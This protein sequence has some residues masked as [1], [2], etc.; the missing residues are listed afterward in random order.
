MI[1]EVCSIPRRYGSP[2]AQFKAFWDSTGQLWQKGSLLGKTGGFFF[3]TA[4]QGG[5]QET[6]AWTGELPTH[7]DNYRFGLAGARMCGHVAGVGVEVARV[8]WRRQPL[9]CPVMLHSN[10]SCLRCRFECMIPTAYRS[11]L[12]CSDH[13]AGAPRDDLRSTGLH[14]SEWCPVPG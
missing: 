13:A 10:S 8:W 14:G 12:E 2:P 5:G 7:A 9:C 3:S 6:T 11:G 1:D 4:T